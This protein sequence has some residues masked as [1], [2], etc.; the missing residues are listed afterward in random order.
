MVKLIL[1]LRPG[2]AEKGEAYNDF[3]M[4]L[5]ALPGLRRKAVSNVYGSMR[6]PAPFGTV[7]EAYFDSREAMEAALVSQTGVETGHALL[8]LTGEAVI[9][10]YADTLEE[11]YPEPLEEGEAGG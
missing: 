1:L 4:K 11:S 6:L 5:E 8:D 3:L 2:I 7:V 9:A 10:L